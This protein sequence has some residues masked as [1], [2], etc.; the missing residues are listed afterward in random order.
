MT[1]FFHHLKKE[2]NV[3]RKKNY[4]EALFVVLATTS[5]GEAKIFTCD[6]PFLIFLDNCFLDGLVIVASL[7]T[8]TSLTST[9]AEL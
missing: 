5:Q 1:Y 3:G 7:S 6:E 8:W 2:V 9:I 4:L